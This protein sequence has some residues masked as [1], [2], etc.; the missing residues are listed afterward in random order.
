M[1]DKLPKGQVLCENRLDFSEAKIEVDEANNT[2]NIRN[3]A[4]LGSESANGY[5][6]DPEAMVKAVSKYEG[7]KSFID[8]NSGGIFGSPGRSVRD[9]AGVF[10]NVKFADFKI[11]GDFIGVQNENGKLVTDIAKSMP[12]V[13]GFSHVARGRMSK[14]GKTIEEIMSVESVDLVAEPATNAGIFESKQD[15]ADTKI[16]KGRNMEWN[17][18]T[19]E[20]IRQNRPELLASVLKEGK[21]T[22]D[23]EVKKLAEERDELKVKLDKC[24]LEQVEREKAETISK[25][26]ADSKLTKDQI[27]D[28]FREL[29]LG[30]TEQD[31]K[32]VEEQAKRLIDDRL[33]TAL[34]ARG[35]V[36]NMGGGKDNS[37]GGD[38]VEV[39]EADDALATH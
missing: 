11:R 26:L 22:R 9:L 39:A 6:Y 4:I 1:K 3:V 12:N 19:I 13:A 31:G 7:V 14:D 8:H 18:V 32:T 34:A 21:A 15:E 5:R 2:F 27:T 28:V 24:A 17:E 30:L 23:D 29:L 36:R 20:G 35:G 25:L 38:K 10:Q 16:R 33:A 37:G